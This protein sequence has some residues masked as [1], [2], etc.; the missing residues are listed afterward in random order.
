MNAVPA[1]G[2]SIRLAGGD[3]ALLAILAAL[4][5]VLILPLG[6]SITDDT[7]IHMQYARNLAEDG[8]LAFNRGDPT[9]GA[10]SPLWVGILSIVY[11]AGGDLIRWSGI[12][13]RLFGFGCVLLVYIHIL[14]L[15]GGRTSAAAGGL[16]MACE[17]WLLRWSSVG[18]ETSLAV[19]MVIAVL[20]SFLR[21]PESAAR[22]L[23]FGLLLFM[24]FLARPE[25]LLLAPLAL[26]SALAGRGENGRFKVRFAWLALFIPLLAAWFIVIRSHTGTFFP[27]TAGAKQGQISLSAG[28]LRRAAVP[29]KILGA[30]VAVPAAG[31]VLLIARGLWKDRDLLRIEP[32]DRRPG[33]VL[34]LL[35][36]AALPAVYLLL[37]FQILSRYM[38]PVSPAV[39][40]LGTVGIE[41]LSRSRAGAVRGGRGIVL[42]A[43]CLSIIVNLLF[44]TKVV[45]GP[46][47]DFSLGLKTVIVEMG[48]YLESHS[49]EDAVIAAPDIGAVGYYSKR[50][51]LDLG[52]LVTPEINRMRADIDVERIIAEGL[53]LDLGAD[54]L[55]DRSEVPFRFEGK[56]IRGCLFS[57]VMSGRVA[58]LGIRKPEPVTYVLYRLERKEGVPDR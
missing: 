36:I 22:S 16:M 11:S 49:G 17:A 46:T 13:S 30:T 2:R 32:G 44:Y 53:Y 1:A 8:E 48:K 31:L 57:P 39:I 25:A 51:I 52:G 47:R 34:T 42:S 5:S 45:V 33:V 54:Y 4:F 40:A 9:Y 3:Y 28:L 37:D 56:V 6:D 50:R 18:M 43:A 12:L 41:R 58:N 55:L 24:A 26:V 38:L 15:G 10:T 19:F 29:V 23:L 35:W 14:A 27:L 7:Y 20:L 21:A